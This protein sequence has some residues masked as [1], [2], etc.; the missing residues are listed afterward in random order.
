MPLLHAQQDKALSAP[1][2]RRLPWPK[3]IDLALL[4]F[5]AMVIGLADRINIAVAAP[6]LM[7]ER[8]WDTVQMGWVLSG[9]YIG[10]AL[11]MVPVGALADRYSPKWVLGFSVAWWSL[12]TALTP[13]P[14]SL[15]G[16]AIVRIL[17][18]LGQSGVIPCIN[19]IL[20]RWF[21]RHEY[22]RATVFGWSGGSAGAILAFPLASA[23]LNFW[24][25]QAVFFLICLP[26]ST[27]ASLLDH[28]SH[29]QSCSL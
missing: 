25:W 29:R 9:F 20:V 12:F 26:G 7:K 18:G 14:D 13:L 21:P 6:I 3:R 8:R 19:S 22:S 28:W 1:F 27:L 16:M 24:G 2:V 23:V 4:S 15:I 5:L 17:V 10:Y 11:L